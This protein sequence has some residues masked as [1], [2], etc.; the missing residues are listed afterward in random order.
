MRNVVAAPRHPYLYGIG[1][2]ADVPRTYTLEGNRLMLFPPS[3][4]PGR[5]ESLAW[6]ALPA[7]SPS[8]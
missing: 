4:T 7:T 1:P 2:G 8:Q 5:Q 3:T 6:E